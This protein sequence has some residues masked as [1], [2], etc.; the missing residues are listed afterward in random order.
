[1]YELTKEELILKC[2][3]LQAENKALH[4]ELEHLSDAYHE[5]EQKHSDE[6]I[7]SLKIKIEW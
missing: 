3:R 4:T 2:K 6:A 5:L 7:K 1:M